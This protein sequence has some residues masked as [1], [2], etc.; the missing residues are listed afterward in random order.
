MTGA[1]L[2]NYPSNSN[3]YSIGKH[4]DLIKGMLQKDFRVVTLQWFHECYMFL[5]FNKCHYHMCLGKNIDNDN[6]T[7]DKSFLENNSEEIILGIRTCNKLAFDIHIK[8]VCKKLAKNFVQYREYLV[9]LK[10]TKKK[11]IFNGMI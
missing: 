9:I 8:N 1:F 6:F 4:L 10:Q 7:F 5:N 2:G 3:L 11:L